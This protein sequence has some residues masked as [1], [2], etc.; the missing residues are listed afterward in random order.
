MVL[1]SS[2][3]GA[4][5]PKYLGGASKT[6]TFL[7]ACISIIYSQTGN[8]A[9]LLKFCALFRCRIFCVRICRRSFRISRVWWFLRN[10]CSILFTFI[11]IPYIRRAKKILHCQKTAS[12]PII[13]GWF[14][15]Y[16]MKKRTPVELRF[17]SLWSS[18][19]DLQNQRKITQMLI[20]ICVYLSP[21]RRVFMV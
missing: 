5:L 2:K 21:T 18:Q 19:N 17:F 10:F 8:F 13:A 4:K 7:L 9:V 16:A 11:G 6:A 20:K 15:P 14:S 3:T 12:S 1:L